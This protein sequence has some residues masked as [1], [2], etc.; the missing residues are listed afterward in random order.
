MRTTKSRW[1]VSQFP[2]LLFKNDN[3]LNVLSSSTLP[4]TCTWAN[5]NFHE[6]KELRWDEGIA[7][8]LAPMLG[9]WVHGHG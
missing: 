4:S 8:K 6:L 3:K 2:N 1:I 9:Y 7:R 5:Y